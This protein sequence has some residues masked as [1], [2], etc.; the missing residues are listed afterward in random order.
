MFMLLFSVQIFNFYQWISHDAVEFESRF[1]LRIDQDN[2]FEELQGY[3]ILFT[4][5][6][7]S[8][9]ML[10][11]LL[12]LPVALSIRD[13]KNVWYYLHAVTTSNMVTIWY[14]FAPLIQ[15]VIKYEF[16]LMMLFLTGIG[17]GYIQII[18]KLI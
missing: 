6:P 17:Y 12:S 11:I 2:T 1:K 13:V 10:M 9:L 14:C 7:C 8:R 5:I 18:V 16:I 4:I 3:I 15:S